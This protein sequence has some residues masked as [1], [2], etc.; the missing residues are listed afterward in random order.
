M[1]MV[2]SGKTRLL[3]ETLA[4]SELD[5]ANIPAELAQRLR[6]GRATVRS[7]EGQMRMAP[8]QRLANTAELGTKLREARA[9]LDNLAAEIRSDNP[10]FGERMSTISEIVDQIP[11]GGALVAF[12][13]TTHGTVVFVV[14]SNAKTLKPQNIVRIPHFNSDTLNQLL[15]ER[16][17]QS[18]VALIQAAAEIRTP[19][20][21][22]QWLEAQSEFMINLWASLIEPVHT[23]LAELGV[24]EE[25][26]LLVL[27]QGGLWLLALHAASRP[28]NGRQRALADD[29]IIIY[30]PSIYVRKVCLSRRAAREA[31]AATLMA[32]VNPEGDLPFADKE[33]S[34]IS[35][36]FRAP[37]LLPGKKATRDKVLVQAANASYLHF[38][39]HGTYDWAD[40]MLSGLE[41]APP[42]HLL[43]S[44][45]LAEM[46]L[47]SNR[48]VTLSACETGLTDL[49][50][51]PD[52]FVGLPTGFLLAGATGVISTLWKVDD[53]ATYLLMSAFYDQ[54]L[55]QSLSPEE[56][57]RASQQ[58]IRDLTL[59]KID[60]FG[61]NDRDLINQRYQ[62]WIGYLS[63]KDKIFD[64]PFFW[65]G[66]TFIGA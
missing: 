57:L 37:I 17:P 43:L 8:R 63:T 66:F 16:Q 51:A 50:G 20:Q 28:V 24:K 12:T 54:H 21:F 30:T 3:A 11:K 52:E 56:A 19:D 4:F 29:H 62:A 49:R 45:I 58:W 27:P 61:Q 60:E 31:Q 38:A 53:A 46:T 14:E 59:D 41:L 55:K 35:R 48:L 26:P 47:D 10:H 18:W 25:A 15:D 13:I 2:E 36:H 34:L 65:A 23:Q 33:A 1:V 9:L 22:R 39:C 7:L 42:D 6:S 40:T 32:V 64:N 44:G 5:L